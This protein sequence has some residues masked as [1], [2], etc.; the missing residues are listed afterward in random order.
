MDAEKK[1]DESGGFIPPLI[2]KLNA[3]GL[4]KEIADCCRDAAY[5]SFPLNVFL[6]MLKSV[7]EYAVEKND[8]ELNVMMLRLGLYDVPAR[9]VDDAILGE[10]EKL[11]EGKEKW[12]ERLKGAY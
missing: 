8:P 4:L 11:K 9:E 1:T 3:P 5:M 12:L 6:R 2:W 7:A 10:L